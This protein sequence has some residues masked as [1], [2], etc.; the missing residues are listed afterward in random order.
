MT[1]MTLLNDFLKKKCFDK[2]H[3]RTK[4]CINTHLGQIKKGVLGK[5]YFMHFMKSERVYNNCELLVGIY[6]IC[7]CWV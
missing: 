5:Y 2:I 3:Q 1:L 6:N 7:E 4:T